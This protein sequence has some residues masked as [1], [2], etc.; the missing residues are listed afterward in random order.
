MSLDRSKG[1]LLN[2]VYGENIAEEITI[3]L[4]LKFNLENIFNVQL[5]IKQILNEISKNLMLN[6]TEITI[7]TVELLSNICPKMTFDFLP[8]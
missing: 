2:D 4:F 5:N 8:G 6:N 3:K 7:D 1:V